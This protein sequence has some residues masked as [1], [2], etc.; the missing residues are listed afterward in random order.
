MVSRTMIERMKPVKKIQEKRIR[1]SQFTPKSY[2]AM[3]ILEELFI[4][5]AAHDFT[6]GN[7][8]K[9]RNFR[10]N[11]NEYVSGKVMSLCNYSHNF[12]R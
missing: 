6:L 4:L 11:P 7:W 9:Q 8:F 5:I 10:P 1:D 3:Q 12:M 2:K